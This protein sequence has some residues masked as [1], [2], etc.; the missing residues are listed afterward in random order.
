MPP[1]QTR[2]TCYNRIATRCFVSSTCFLQTKHSDLTCG[3]RS[4]DN[5]L[6][7]LFEEWKLTQSI[8]T[9]QLVDAAKFTEHS[10]EKCHYFISFNSTKKNSMV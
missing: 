3:R 10:I 2:I 4:Q 6:F 5:G 7:M 8:E 1:L 9:H